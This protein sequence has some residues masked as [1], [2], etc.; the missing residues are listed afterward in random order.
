M[1]D[2]Q[3][4]LLAF[5]AIWLCDLVHRPEFEILLGEEEARRVRAEADEML[6][7]VLDG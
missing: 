2:D 5:K 3:R 1:P 7:E 6:R 4:D